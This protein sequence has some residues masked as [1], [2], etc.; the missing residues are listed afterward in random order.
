MLKEKAS[1]FQKHDKA[2]F[3][4]EFTDNMA[5]TIKAKKQP[6]QAITEVSGPNKRQPFRGGPSQNKMCG[7]LRQYKVTNKVMVKCFSLKGIVPFH[8]ISLPN[9]TLSSMEVLT[10]AY[11]VLK[12][13]FSK[14][15]A[16]ICPLTGRLKHFLPVWRLLTKDQRVLSLVEGFRFPLLQEPKQMFSPKPQLKN[17]DQKELIDLEQRSERTDRL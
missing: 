2:L 16:P 5:E 15:T 4:E 12:H 10:H 8:N 13:L 17:K 11:P 3:G 7:G 1:V 14:M 6:T 9:P